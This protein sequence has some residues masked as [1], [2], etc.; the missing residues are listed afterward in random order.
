MKFEF[1]TAQRILFGAGTA[2]EIAAQAAGLGRRPLVVTGKDASRTSAIVDDLH[3][4][5][6]E[7]LE[8]FRVSGEPTTETITDGAALGRRCGCDLVISV[9]GGSVIDTGKAIAAL[10]TNSGQLLDYLEIIGN[11]CAIECEPVPHIAAPTTAGTGAEVTHNSV[12]GSKS[13]GVKVSMR[14]PLM[15]PTVVVVDPLLTLGVP[16]AITATTGLDALTQLIESF[17]SLKAN[18]LTDGLCREGLCRGAR[19]LL[20]AYRHGDDIAAREEMCLASLFSGMALANAKLGAVHGFAGPM[21]GMYD[22][23]HG[24]ICA[25]LLPAVIEANVRALEERRPDSPAFARYDEIAAVLTG[26]PS[27]RAVDGIEWLNSLYAELTLPTLRDIG[28]APSEYPLVA[29]KAG[30]A[31]SM[32]GNPIELTEDELVAILHR[33]DEVNVQD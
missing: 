30:R 8:Q 26:E 32:K 9:G 5:A 31:S 16:P 11:G 19:S 1:A 29:Q 20:Q 4:Q 25:R 15:Q 23:P 13:N 10:L 18:P 33:A 7:R 27:A 3:R 21:G 12:I 2:A 24:A 22:A 17:V 6:I 14:S 28:V